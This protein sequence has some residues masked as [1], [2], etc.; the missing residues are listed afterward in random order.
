MSR[1][2]WG[3]T[4]IVLGLWLWLSNM[5]YL[6]FK[7]DWPIILIAIGIYEVIIGLSGGRKAPRTK[8]VLDK[9]EKGKISAEDAVNLLKDED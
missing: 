5:G 6:N 4:L 7:R 2:F 3:F 1:F 8:K 9:L